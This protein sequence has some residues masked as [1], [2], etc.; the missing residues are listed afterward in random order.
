MIQ[1]PAHFGSVVMAMVNV[2]C[3]WLCS[4][5]VALC[6]C[7]VQCPKGSIEYH[8]VFMYP[9]IPVP[10]GLT[11]VRTRVSAIHYPFDRSISTNNKCIAMLDIE[12]GQVPNHPGPRICFSFFTHEAIYHRL[13]AGDWLVLM[14]DSEGGLWQVRHGRMP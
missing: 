6:G 7:T 10:T 3:M 5:L 2:R 12:S 8:N 9:D 4:I 1:S 11:T 14:F 13:R